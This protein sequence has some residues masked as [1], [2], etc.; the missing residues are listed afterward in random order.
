ML[1]ANSRVVIVHFNILMT[2]S[3]FYTTSV[4]VKYHGERCGIYAKY[5]LENYPTVPRDEIT[6]YVL[7]QPN[8]VDSW[9]HV[10]ICES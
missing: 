5:N 4:S 2:V 6:S 3:W 8:D 9:L 7:S 1:A 10:K